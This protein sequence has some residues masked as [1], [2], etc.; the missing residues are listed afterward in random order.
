MINLNRTLN[1]E[2]T[3][4]RVRNYS[5]WKCTCI[6]SKIGS[7]CNQSLMM[8]TA[9]PPYSPDLVLFN[10]YLFKLESRKLF[11]LKNLEG[12][13]N[14]QSA[15]AKTSN[16]TF[17]F[18]YFAQKILNLYHYVWSSNDIFIVA[19]S[20][21]PLNPRIDVVSTGNTKKNPIFRKIISLPSRIMKSINAG[22][23]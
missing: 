21:G 22:T 7:G 8:G 20:K 1:R 3:K 11:G 13:K 18:F 5:T 17:L 16:K 23:S 10:L 9:I 14:M 12:R 2:R 19:N 4:T 6:Q 15:M